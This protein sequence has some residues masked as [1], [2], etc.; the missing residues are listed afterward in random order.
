[1][2]FGT[3]IQKARIDKGWKQN[4][5]RL[6]LGLTK[7]QMSLLENNK[8]DPRLSLIRQVARVLG[9]PVTQLVREEG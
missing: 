6:L 9:V 2:S 7:Q 5:L 1:M 4:D 3:E 8:R